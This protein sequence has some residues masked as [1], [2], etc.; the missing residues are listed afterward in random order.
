MTGEVTEVPDGVSIAFQGVDGGPLC[1]DSC[2]TLPNA[3]QSQLLGEVLVVPKV[4]G[5]AVPVAALETKADG[6]T[7]VL[8]IDDGEPVSRQVRVVAV[9]N[10]IA[11]IDGI[12]AGQEVL[13]RNAK[14]ESTG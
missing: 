2:D 12:S 4:T 14:N 9:A 3:S 10:G 1:G 13:I 7:W 8:L 11:I 5:L 6:T